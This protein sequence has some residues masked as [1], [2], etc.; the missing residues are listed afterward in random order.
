MHSAVTPFLL[1]HWKAGARREQRTGWQG[2]SPEF[3]DI[4]VT[5]PLNP[6][7]SESVVAEVRGGSIP[8]ATFESRG[9][10]AEV[11]SRPTLN[12]ITLR[13]GDAMVHTSRNRLA[14]THRGRA[15]HMRYGGD[16]YRLWAVDRRRYVLTRQPDSEDPGTR[17]T[18]TQSGRGRR[19]QITVTAT[20][21]AVAADIALAALFT[22]VDRSVLTRRGTLRA[23]VSRAFGLFAQTQY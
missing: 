15:L 2:M 21:R 19:R 22:G 11:L 13:L 5:S 8:T 10:H 6:S 12:S 7:N 14:L 1:H 23:F 17:I 18:V 9:I 20:G 3:G 16:R 4:K